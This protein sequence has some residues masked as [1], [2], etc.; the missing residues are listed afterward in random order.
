MSPTDR[1]EVHTLRSRVEPERTIKAVVMGSVEYMG[2]EFWLVAAP[3]NTLVES[4]KAIM[5]LCGARGTLAYVVY[6]PAI[7]WE[8][9]TP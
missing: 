5:P 8:M 7:E 3:P 9:A 4:W 6:L 2:E 1:L